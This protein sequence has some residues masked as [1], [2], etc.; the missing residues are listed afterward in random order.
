MGK[1]FPFY[2][3]NFEENGS[4]LALACLSTHVHANG[5]LL[6]MLN[7]HFQFVTF[8]VTFAGAFK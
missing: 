4:I 8:T 3:P 2:V 6:G 5:H 7:R 1:G